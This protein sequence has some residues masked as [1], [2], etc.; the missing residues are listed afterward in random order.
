MTILFNILYIISSLYIFIIN[1]NKNNNFYTNI[2]ILILILLI[3]QNIKYHN[4]INYIFKIIYLIFIF[5]NVSYLYLNNLEN[6]IHGLSLSTLIII[7]FLV[8]IT[9]LKINLVVKIIMILI[10][11]FLY[12]FFTNLY[13]NINKLINNNNFIRLLEYNPKNI[14][15]A[16]CIS[17]KI[18][19]NIEKI[20]KSW[21]ENLL[22]Y[23]DVDIFMNIDK[24]NNYINNIIKP[25]KCILFNELLE[26]KN[27]DINSYTMFYRIY[28]CNNY[29]IEYEK[30]N[31]FEYDIIIRMRCDI[32]LFE[33]LYL[34][35]FKKNIIYFP[36]RNVKAETSNIYNLGI[37]DQ[38]FI[39]D[40]QTINKICNIY[41]NLNKTYLK[42]INCKIPEVTLL[43]YLK[44]N[45]I[46]YIYFYYSWIINY[47]N[48]F[49]TSFNIKFL[50][51]ILF[52]FNNNCFININKLK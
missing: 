12:Y 19:N 36:T 1:I 8:N 2:Y 33:R 26:S 13:L 23:Y 22:K 11:I 3:I 46:K 14:R 10:I 35:N 50:K 49:N 38:L 39:G 43:Y 45:K 18:D 40:R 27:L 44:K 32:I 25:K 21:E 42:K 48:G 37:T 41:L 51:K 6:I 20:Y 24:S 16:L 17:G 28:E 15:V 30:K 7:L 29:S 47:Y 34:E 52:I 4:D 5:I 31:N 9:N